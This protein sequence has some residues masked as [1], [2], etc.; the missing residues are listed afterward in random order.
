MVSV[1]EALK[2]KEN[3]LF[4]AMSIEALEAKLEPENRGGQGSGK[5]KSKPPIN[6]TVSDLLLEIKNNFAD[7]Y[8]HDLLDA[9]EEIPQDLAGKLRLIASRHGRWTADLSPLG[10]LIAADFCEDAG[11]I[12]EDVDKALSPKPPREFLGPCSQGECSGE[13]YRNPGEGFTTCP[14]CG[15]RQSV[16]EQQAWIKSRFEELLLDRR[17]CWS[18]L[19]VAGFEITRSAF[20]KW[21]ERGHVEPVE[22]GLYPWSQVREL[23]EKYVSRKP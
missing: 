1:Q 10:P 11:R 14:K 15:I 4:V 12:A 8:A 2:A 13:L 3:I 16:A 19:K 5:P 22:D 21:F 18:A 9:G 23:A 20:K 7:F 6:L 17:E